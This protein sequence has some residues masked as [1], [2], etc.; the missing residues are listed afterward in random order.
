LKEVLLESSDKITR[1]LG[2]LGGQASLF[3][4][5]SV[6]E[7][8][9]K[10]LDLPLYTLFHLLHLHHILLIECLTIERHGSLHYGLKEL[11]P[12]VKAPWLHH[13]LS[14]LELVARIEYL[15]DQV[16]NLARALTLVERVDHS[17]D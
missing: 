7:L 15:A 8:G 13:V 5:Q 9:S 17:V 11:D 2:A 12:W 16:Y 10:P 6:A 3:G 4:E 14:D 1:G